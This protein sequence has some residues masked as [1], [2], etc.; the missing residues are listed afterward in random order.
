MIKNINFLSEI[1][2]KKNWLTIF[3]IDDTLLRFENIHNS[4]WEKNINHHH[5]ITG[6]KKKAEEIAL[7]EWKQLVSIS[8]PKHVDKEGLENLVEEIKI[9][10]NDKI[11]LVTHRSNDILHHT[12]QH[13]E[14][15]NIIYDE[16]HLTAGGSKG[17]QILS[18][19]KK[20][21]NI[22]GIIFVDDK[23]SNIIDVIEKISPLGLNLDC[24]HIQIL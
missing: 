23:K 22:D 11:I 16:L 3:D 13:L 12:L 4:W 20:Y 10:N 7:N 1:I 21:K 19:L 15:L 14:K 8:E 17:N 5:N 2:P 9:K 24:Y 18:I 6:C